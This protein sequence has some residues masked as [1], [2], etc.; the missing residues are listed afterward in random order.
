MNQKE[1]TQHFT[2]LHLTAKETKL[3]NTIMISAPVLLHDNDIF[4]EEEQACLRSISLKAQKSVL[5]KK[6]FSDL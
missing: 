1:I 6:S 4:S 3:I 2:N 5:N